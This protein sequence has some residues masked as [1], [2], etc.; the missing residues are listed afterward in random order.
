MG[1]QVSGQG[2]LTRGLAAGEGWGRMG[3]VL[4]LSAIHNEGWDHECM[5]EG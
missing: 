4:Y 2:L 5:G 1:A 3:E